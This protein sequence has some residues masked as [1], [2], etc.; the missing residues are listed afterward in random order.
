MYISGS[1][2]VLK[3]FGKVWKLK[4]PFSRTWK[5]LDKEI[6]EV[7]MEKF[8]IFVWKNSKKYPKMDVA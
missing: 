1:V 2:R 5:A 7:P 6:S 3:S 4:M 8:W